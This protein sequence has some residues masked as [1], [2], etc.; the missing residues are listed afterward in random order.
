MLYD[1]LIIGAGPAG[2]TAG[3]YAKRANLNVA[4]F[5]KY[6]PGGQ[7]INTAEIENYTG[8]QKMSGYELAT[9]ML[10][11][12]ESLSVEIKYEE[13]LEV[14]DEGKVKKVV[15][16]DATYETKVVIIASGTVPRRL[17]VENEDMLAS[18]GISW[19]AICDG[20]MYKNKEVIVVGGGNS[21][22]EEASYLATLATKVTV[23][24]DM[25]HLTADKKAQDIL[26]SKANVDF[27]FSS[28]VNK[29]VLGNSGEMLGV[30]IT[31]SKGEK[32]VINAD[33][34]FEYIGLIPVTTF[35]SKLGITNKFGY[36][37]ANEKMETKV[38]GVYG[39][40]D[41]NVKQIRQVVTATSDGAI[42]VQNA[43]K[44]LETL[45]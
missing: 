7:I 2:M 28:K 6:A 20:P 3:I 39:A 22:V 40:G 36:I 35:V 43:L 44:Y 31:N 17:G 42:A 19:C 16:P 13:V 8:Y 27:R 25:P 34:A 38:A 41:S 24:Q 10:K 12:T 26:T 5:E 1:V 14:I 23:I 37:E 4:I 32:E 33:G 11:H 21:A 29:F 45:N 9:H 18:R 30:E 15:T